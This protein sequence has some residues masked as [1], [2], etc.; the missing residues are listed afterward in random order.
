MK[1]NYFRKNI[2]KSKRLSNFWRKTTDGEVLYRRLSKGTTQV[3][4]FLILNRYRTC[5]KLS[6]RLPSGS[7]C[8]KPGKLLKNIKPYCFKSYFE[9]Q[10]SSSEK[11]I[12]IPSVNTAKHISLEKWQHFSSLD[13]N[14]CFR[15]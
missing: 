14:I 1:E 6:G 5:L 7:Y 8:P 13:G 11:L 3:V 9:M 15:G 10:L 12:L 4:P 2:Y